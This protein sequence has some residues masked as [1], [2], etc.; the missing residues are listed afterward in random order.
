MQITEVLHS[1]SN[2]HVAEAAI[3]S[4]GGSFASRLERVAFS[5]GVTPGVF[6]AIAV[7]KFGRLARPE[8]MRVVAHAMAGSDQPVLNG[9]RTILES[10]LDAQDEDEFDEEDEI[11][12]RRGDDSA[13]HAAR[14]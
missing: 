14:Y 1:C 9:L 2:A 12:A 3:L 7:R 8:D 4:I 13:R 6:A 11:P 10:V 5:Q